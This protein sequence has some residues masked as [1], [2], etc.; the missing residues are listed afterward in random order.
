MPRGFPGFPW[1]LLADPFQA[2][3]SP[4]AALEPR[5]LRVHPKMASQRAVAHP[6]AY[7]QFFETKNCIVEIWDCSSY[8]GLTVHSADITLRA[9][10][11]HKGRVNDPAVTQSIAITSMPKSS[12]T[13]AE[14]SSRTGNRRSDP[15][16]LSRAVNFDRFHRS[17]L[18][19]SPA[20]VAET[21]RRGG[22]RGVTPPLER[23]ERS[24]RMNCVPSYNRTILSSPSRYQGI[25]CSRFD[26]HGGLQSVSPALYFIFNVDPVPRGTTSCC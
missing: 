24:H 15:D 20:L 11:G 14:I 5:P 16:P 26:I 17:R 12:I 1:L 13:I 19:H 2:S 6:I 23:T 21:G 22:R 4:R 3:R 9:P 18:L 10:W 7:M 8:D 25:V